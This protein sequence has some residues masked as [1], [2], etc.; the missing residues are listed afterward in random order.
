MK[1]QIYL[2]WFVNFVFDADLVLINT[3]AADV[4]S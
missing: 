4:V 1:L 2:Y 3:T